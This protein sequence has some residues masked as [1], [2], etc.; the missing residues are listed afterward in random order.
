M[1]EVNR[2]CLSRLKKKKNLTQQEELCTLNKTRLLAGVP[3][4]SIP[5]GWCVHTLKASL[6][7]SIPSLHSKTLE[8]C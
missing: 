5:A 1:T 8:T 3:S 7:R 6:K 4:Q 2:P